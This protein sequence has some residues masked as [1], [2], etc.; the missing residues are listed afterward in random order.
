[1]SEEFE[2]ELEEGLTC[3]SEAVGS[4]A[5]SNGRR[6]LACA[7]RLVHSLPDAEDVVQDVLSQVLF[8]QKAFAR[9]DELGM[10][11]S[12]AVRNKAIEVYRRRVKFARRHLPVSEDLLASRAAGQAGCLTE[13]A[14]AEAEHREVLQRVAEGLDRLPVR[15]YDALKFTVMAPS[16]SSIRDA[17]IESGIPYSTLR[18]RR[19]AGLRSLRRY[20]R[21]KRLISRSAAG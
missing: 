5:S 12:R 13:E 10:Y 16:G 20:L 3:L 6:W 4:L 9:R 8:R 18:H 17:G 1:M 19:Q 7:R 21:K 11:L 15:Q 14:E 2:E